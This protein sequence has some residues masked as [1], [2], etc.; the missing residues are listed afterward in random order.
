MRESELRAKLQDIIAGIDCGRLSVHR[1]ASRAAQLSGALLVATIG[2]GL[3][4]CP[5]KGPSSPGAA[6]PTSSQPTATP[7]TAAD[8]GPVAAYESPAPEPTEV[9]PSPTAPREPSPPID[10]GPRPLYGVEP[11]PP[12]AP[13]TTPRPRPKPRPIQ[14]DPGPVAEYMA[15]D[16]RPRPLY[17]VEVAPSVPPPGPPGPYVP[18]P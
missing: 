11:L 3:A 6:Q 12:S 15:P 9:G 10:R 14:P 7:T 1:P 13:T 4:A 18:V 5:G 17:G 8:R 2:L 16:P